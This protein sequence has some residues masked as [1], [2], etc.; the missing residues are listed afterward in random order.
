MLVTECVQ[1]VQRRKEEFEQYEDYA[2]DLERDVSPF[3]LQPKTKM[4]TNTR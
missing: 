1:L 4:L 3:K 2:N